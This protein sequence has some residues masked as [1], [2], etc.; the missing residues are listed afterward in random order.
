MVTTQQAYDATIFQKQK[1]RRHHQKSTVLHA[2]A[3]ELGF[4]LVPINFVP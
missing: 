2:Q 1:E 3:R 4:P